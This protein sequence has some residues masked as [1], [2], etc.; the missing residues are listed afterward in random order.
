M[1]VRSAALLLLAP[2]ALGAAFLPTAGA[3]ETRLWSPASY[4]AAA[5]E[6]SPETAR[7]RLSRKAASSRWKSAL[8]SAAL[9][10]LSW[11]ADSAP[12]G[13][14]PADSYL[15]H[16]WRLNAS[17]V[18]INT[19]L[20]W[21]L[22]NSFAD[23]LTVR[24][25]SLARD[26]AEAEL[27]SSLRSQ[28]LAALRV[29]YS[30]ALKGRI[31][32][33]SEGNLKAQEA[34]FALTQDLYKHGMKS[35]TDLLKSETD[36]LSSRLRLASAQAETRKSLVRFN[37]LLQRGPLDP[38]EP[39]PLSE[40]GARAFPEPGTELR[41]SL[42]RRPELRIARLEEDKA[43]VSLRRTIREGVPALS[44][45]ALWQRQEVATFG[46]PSAFGIPNPNYRLSLTLALPS[47]FNAYSQAQNALASRSE[48]ERAR[49][50]RRAQEL[51]VGQE[52]ALSRSELE[53]ALQTLRVA[54]RKEE[55]SR[56]NL[57][58]VSEQYQQGRADVIR[59]A[60]AQ[61]DFLES[62]VQRAQAMH[63]AHVAAAE[64]RYAAGEAL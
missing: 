46:K 54:S 6:A 16:N 18:G 15:F 24:A 58:L 63:D 4:V 28:A 55:I 8:A 47:G 21:N 57:G 27:D 1:R 39:E 2:A 50:A 59:L 37:T 41:D 53:R 60:Q 40:P 34:Q 22:F 36:L 23:E 30:L 48:L 62:Q 26:A 51:Q 42:R 56:E 43:A 10:A 45:D 49:E 32:E 17:D 25:S 20:R 31:L 64:Y 9:P 7:S 35:Y 52:V 44:L 29:Y 33:V 3:Q 14:T 12:Y 38:A 11:S 19:G 5:L 13:H 61:L